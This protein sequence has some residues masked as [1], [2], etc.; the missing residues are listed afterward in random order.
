VEDGALGD[1]AKMKDFAQRRWIAQ[2]ADPQTVIMT[3]G[4]E[5]LTVRAAKREGAGGPPRR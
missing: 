4:N 1:E 3:D 5:R 2:E